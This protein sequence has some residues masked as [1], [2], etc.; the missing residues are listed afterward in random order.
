MNL[1]PDGQPD[2]AK[3][4]IAGRRLDDTRWLIIQPL[5]FDRARVTVATEHG[6]GEHY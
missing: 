4:N 2:W 6:T 3:G 1:W 5:T